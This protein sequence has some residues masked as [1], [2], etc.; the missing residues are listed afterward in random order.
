MTGFGDDSGTSW[1][2]CKQSAPRCRQI[3]TPTRHHSISQAGSSSWRPTDSVEA[4]L[5]AVQLAQ[6][7]YDF[8]PL[9]RA[10]S[11]SAMDEGST[12]SKIDDLLRYVSSLVQRQR[13]EVCMYVYMYVIFVRCNRRT[14]LSVDLKH[15]TDGFLKRSY[16]YGFCSV[17]FISRS[18]FEGCP[19]HGRTFS[20]YPCPLSF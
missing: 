10:L 14:F 2:I 11:L 12:D 19:Y 4:S 8:F 9:N 17:R 3:T 7:K 16:R 13:E 5:K 1:T 6:E 20:I 18:R 15:K